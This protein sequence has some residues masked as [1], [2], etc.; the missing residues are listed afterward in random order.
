MRLGVRSGQVYPLPGRVKGRRGTFPVRNAHFVVRRPATAHGGD[1]RF[2]NHRRP[3]KRPGPGA[4]CS[5]RRGSYLILAGSAADRELVPADT[6]T[7][8]PSVVPL[9]Q[10]LQAVRVP[11]TAD[12][13]DAGAPLLYLIA[14]AR[15]V[16]A[17]SRHADQS[18]PLELTCSPYE[19]RHNLEPCDVEGRPGA[20]PA[21][22]AAPRPPPAENF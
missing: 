5:S 9:H 2:R 20:A 13:P 14:P 12:S 17:V 21:A 10:D 22:Y 11:D 8:R 1:V 19:M 18:S 16:V 3:V 4:C 15:D 7:A 6:Q